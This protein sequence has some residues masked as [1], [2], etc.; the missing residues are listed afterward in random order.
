MKK[1]FIVFALLL[2]TCFS[3]KRFDSDKLNHKL[4][5]GEWKQTEIIYTETDEEGTRQVKRDAGTAILKFQADSCTETMPDSK[6]IKHYTFQIKDYILQ[7]KEENLPVNYLEV[8][9]LTDDSLIL[10][11]KYQR[12]GYIRTEP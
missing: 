5:Q 10:Q 8:V 7:L 3:C 9:K 4:I 1:N 12:W 11:T 2:T 6:N